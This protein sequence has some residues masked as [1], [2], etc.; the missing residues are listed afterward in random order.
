MGGDGAKAVGGEEQVSVIA[1]RVRGGEKI[2]PIN[3]QLSGARYAGEAQRQ[4]QTS[5]R[6]KLGSNTV[7]AEIGTGEKRTKGKTPL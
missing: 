1:K 7:F 4:K 3:T 5:F 2:T 6:R